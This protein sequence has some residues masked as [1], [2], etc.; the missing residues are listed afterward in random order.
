MIKPI[1]EIIET[2]K[3]RIGD[4]PDDESV[5]FLEDITD[6]LT[7]YD[8]KTKD[9]TDWKNKYDELD[10]SWKEKYISRFSDVVED[11]KNDVDDEV[12]S[13]ENSAFDI[14]NALAR[15][16]TSIVASKFAFTIRN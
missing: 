11:S 15:T 3:T 13:P 1:S 2:V 4:N 16:S 12:E 14:L 5:A 7:D 9:N 6:T 8:N 10:R